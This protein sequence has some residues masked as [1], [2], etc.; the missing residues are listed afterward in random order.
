ME[1]LYK[2]TSTKFS[3]F[4]DMYFQDSFPEEFAISAKPALIN[5]PRYIHPQQ[6]SHVPAPGKPLDGEA[7]TAFV[8]AVSREIATDLGLK[9]KS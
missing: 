2:M 8:D 7:F 5:Q 1:E 4:Q 6:L 3:G 9:K